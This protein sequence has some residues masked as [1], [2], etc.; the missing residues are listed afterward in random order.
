MRVLLLTLLFGFIGDVSLFAQNYGY[1]GEASDT[2]GLVY[3]RDRCY[4]PET[5][6]FTSK[7]P[8]GVS[9]GSN[10][11]VY[12]N[13]SA[14]N[15]VDPMGTDAIFFAGAGNAEQGAGVAPTYSVFYTAA[16]AQAAAYTKATGEPAYVVQAANKQDVINALAKYADDPIDDIVFIAHN[17]VNSKNGTSGLALGPGPNGNL[18]TTDFSGLDF[19]SFDPDI[20]SAS[21]E[22]CYSA[23]PRVGAAQALAN[24]LDSPV[25]GYDQ[26]VSFTDG[27]PRQASVW[28]AYTWGNFFL[29]LVGQGQNAQTYYGV[30]LPFEQTVQPQATAT[31]SNTSGDDGLED[32]D[33]L[34]GS[35]T[36]QDDIGQPS[37]FSLTDSSLDVGGVL[38]NEAATLVGS[39]LSDIKGATYDP[40]SKQIVFLGSNNVPS[41]TLT[42]INMDYFYTAIQSVYGSATPPYV[43][44]DP[45]ATPY[46]GWTNFTS[47]SDPLF[48]NNQ[49]GG[50]VLLYSPLWGNQSDGVTV[51]IRCND[52]TGTA[53]DFSFNFT[54][55]PSNLVGASGNGQRSMA[56]SYNPSGNVNVPSGLTLNTEYFGPNVLYSL[57]ND[58]TGRELNYIPFQLTNTT[59]KSFLNVS[60]IV[61]PSL[62]HRQYG[63]RVEGT[64]LGWVMYE[65]DRVMKCLSV[66]KDNLTGA[67]YSSTS[68]N[69]NVSGYKNL[70]ELAQSLGETG[71][72]NRLWFEPD[73]MTLQR[74]VDPVSGQATIGF[75]SSTVHLLTEAFLQGVPADPAANAFATFFTQN[76]SAFASQSFPVEDPVN[77]SV[78]DNV[79]I[80]AM[81][82][83][84]MQAVC[85]ARFF[86][87]NNIP[88]DNWWMSSYTPPTATSPVAIPTAYNQSAIGSS[89]WYL[90]YGGVRIHKPNQ[91]VPSSI[92]QNLGS[93]VL[94][95][96]PAS[97]STSSQDVPG[98]V[99]SVPGNMTAVSAS[100]NRSSQDG[101]IKL[102][103]TDVSYASPGSLP[104]HFT[105]Y[106]Q[107]SWT[108]ATNLG[109]G[110]RD[111]RFSLQFSNPS[112]YD[113]YHLLQDGSGKALATLAS[114]DTCVRTGTVRLVDLKT[115][116]YLN[117]TSSLNVTYGLDS[118]GNPLDTLSGLSGTDVPSFTQGSHNSGASLAQSTDGKFTYSLTLPDSSALQFD[119]NGNLLKTTDR[120]GHVKTY[121][122]T[123]S[124]L[125]TISDDAGQTLT[126][127]YST[128]T[129]L[130]SSVTGSSGE[131]ATYHY[132]SNGCL[133]QVVHVP[134]N[135]VIAQYTYNSQN[136]LAGVTRMDGTKSVTTAADQKGRSSVRQDSRGNTTNWTFVQNSDGSTTSSALDLNS[137]LSASTKVTDSMGR[138]ISATNS[139]GH[140]T[141]FGYT[142]TSN[143]PSSIQL[144]ITNRP[145][146]QITR[147]SA[148]APTSIMDPAVSGAQPTQ[149]SYDPTSGKPTQYMDGASHATNL[150]YTT[151]GHNNLK[152]IRRYHNNANLDT[153]YGYDTNDNINSVQDPMS[154][155]WRI[156]HDNVGRVTSI[157]DPTGV[158]VSCHY[159]SQGDVD[160]V[161]DPRLSSN[162]IY[163]HDSLHRIT[164]ITTPTKTATYTYDPVTQ[165][166]DSIT[167]KDSQGNV[168][169]TVSYTYNNT[170]GDL[171]SST[172]Q[173]SQ[174]GSGT[175]T[176]V[177]TTYSYTPYGNLSSVTPEAGQT[178]NLNYNSAG[179]LLGTSETDSGPAVGPAIQASAATTGVWS[180]SNSQVMSWGAPESSLPITGY[181]DA[182]DASA[183]AT[184]NTASNSVAWNGIPDGK[185]IFAVRAVDSA[186][187]WSPQSVFNLWIDTT[188][189]AVSNVTVTPNPIPQGTVTVTVGATVSDA[190]SGLAGAPEFRWCVS[191]DSSRNWSSYQTMS[192]SG[193]QY[194]ASV[195]E[196]GSGQTLYYQIESQDI[197]GNT[198]V[199]GGSASIS[200]T[201][202]Q[203]WLVAHNLSANTADAATPDGDGVP[204]LLKYATGM[205]PG[206]MS[207]GGAATI[208]NG[209]NYLT[210]S[211]NRL[212][213]VTNT[214]S[215]I[216]E[217]SSDLVNWSSIATLAS[218][219]T[220]WTGPAT[221]TET[222][223]SPV[224]VTVSDS[225][226]YSASGP[227]FLRL[228][229]TTATDTSVPGTVPQGD[230][231]L[232]PAPSSTSASSLPLDNTPEAR[233]T[234]Q[235]LT[236]GAFTVASAGNWSTTGSPYALRLLSG[237][238]SGATFVITGQSGNVLT[239]AT[240]GIDLTQLAAVGDTY[241]VMPLETLGTLFGTT[242]V[243][244]Q[245]GSSAISAD[246]IDLWTG[247][248]WSTFYNNGTN[249]KQAGS[250]LTQNNT[251]IPPG[252]GW[253]T[254]R[255]GSSS[256]TIYVIGRVPEVALR[257]FVPNGQTFIAGI[258]P[259]PATF[260][261]TG[262][263]AATNWLDG[264]S[265][266]AADDVLTWSGTAWS[267][268]YNN[269]TNWKQAGSLLNQN[270]TVVP[271]GQPFLIVRQS[272]V[273][274]NQ[275]LILQPLNYTP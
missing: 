188:P 36:L 33:N 193:S 93:A 162:V 200:L 4:D 83:Q 159:N 17:Y 27:Q 47:A 229:V 174:P 179:Q 184:V 267:T 251:L 146:I 241:E 115:G 50:F 97:T 155:M 101:N 153:T 98:Q 49:I 201:P 15:S 92:A 75:Q 223:S 79:P 58:S 204:I 187:N 235:A 253:L 230:F 91:Y 61:I 48:E 5:G 173:L 227:R 2:S 247:T 24:A 265:A 178:V 275:A 107:S 197:A 57:S 18:L 261:S 176:P 117:F 111:S 226:T 233:G 180:T 55:V 90:I 132:D 213:P 108:A 171:T 240:N 139:L 191:S 123:N 3:L 76:Y 39:N 262:F 66:G 64:K 94:T 134:S 118:N 164:S 116:N 99:W 119:S 71:G 271:G 131:G 221:V 100:L 74:Y 105:R 270:N 217:A 110:W 46:T 215:Y 192:G 122:Y 263:A 43:T 254:I 11:Y 78:I 269:G 258:S 183:P 130:L 190:M 34:D 237:G 28:T 168:L 224:A 196:T 63:G 65:A 218:G 222:G 121:S 1:A 186:G 238:G 60:V 32:F 245:T 23:L 266:I 157:S 84:A 199:Y 231:P 30:G 120:H 167:Q 239:L 202:Y 208:G 42:S 106:Y 206:T 181:S 72:Y 150:L 52:T 89:P 125:A 149:I 198:G 234:V 113:Q 175:T 264:A 9:S 7:D 145:A 51:R 252:A 250:L 225:V 14:P 88:L 31:N 161:T 246:N 243:P 6:R 177:T 87:D 154:N 255:Q 207:A 166:V 37:N 20:G 189:P 81:L 143:L 128:T 62:Q 41:S 44:L 133:Y 152:T 112:L 69:V 195:Q 242:N 142:G 21:V 19:S 16:Q 172:L 104:L 138:I 249:W 163:Q 96:R 45:P 156:G 268:F 54:A 147:N 136:Q 216:V 86:H 109:P 56:L 248:A 77:P 126:L 259:L 170:T 59:G 35:T 80:F 220:S 73:D 26:E 114:G 67:S 8:L 273:T 95:S 232:S 260:S 40:T 103:E 272:S 210:L 68:G 158:T 160:Y 182:E 29:N 140:T 25:T 129:G 214:F 169:Q 244:F 212:N 137:G 274:P 185:H 124:Q 211:F 236:T 205:T 53:Y 194:S 102:S 13:D 38:I 256:F 82:Q 209:G 141:G 257:Q 219:A 144:P 148:G 12:V 10:G 203:Q 135:A 228:R 165:W 70:E 22:A 85:L 151:D 127:A